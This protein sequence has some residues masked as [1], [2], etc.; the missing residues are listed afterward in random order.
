MMDSAARA[1]RY[2]TFDDIGYCFYKL[3]GERV[4][5]SWTQDQG[6]SWTSVENPL[7]GVL[8]NISEP[9]M[10]PKG[11]LRFTFESSN[12]WVMMERNMENFEHKFLKTQS[13]GTM[14]QE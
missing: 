12:G 10:S 11:Y 9:E 1:T 7:M 5:V 6:E 4:Y 14:L 8:E 2:F 13:R 3:L